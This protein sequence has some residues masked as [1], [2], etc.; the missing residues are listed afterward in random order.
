MVAAAQNTNNMTIRS[1]L[2]AEKLTGSKFTNWYS[3]YHETV[4]IGRVRSRRTKKAREAK[5]KDNGKNKLAYD[6]KPKIPPP[7]KR[8]NPGKDF[9]CH[10]CK[11]GLRERKKLKHGALSLY[12]GNGMLA[13]VETIGSFD[14]ILP[15]GILI[16][17]ENYHFAPFVTRGVVL[18]SRLVNNGYIHTFTNYGISVSKDNVFYFNAIPRNGI[19]EIDTHNLYPNVSSMFNVNNKR[20]KH[21]LDSSYL[22]YCRLGH[23]NKK[24][25]DKLQRDGILQPTH[26]ESLEKCKSCI[27]EKMARKSF[28]HQVERAKDL[29]GLIHT[30]GCEALVKRDAPDKLDPRSI[31][32]IFIG[33][34]KETISYYFYYPFENKIFVAQNAEF[35]ENRLMS[36][37]LSKDNPKEILDGKLQ[38]GDTPMIEKHDYRK[39]QGAKTPSEVQY[40]KSAKKSTNAMSSTEAEYIAAAEASMES[41]WM[42]KFIVGLGDDNVVDPFTKPM[43][44]D[45]HYE[46]A[47]A[48]G[49]VPA[50]SRIEVDLSKDMSGLESPPRTLKKLLGDEGLSS[51]GTQ[52]N[53]IFITADV[54]LTKPNDKGRMNENPDGTHQTSLTNVKT[55]FPSLAFIKENIDVLRTMINE[56]DQQAKMKA[57]P[58]KLAYANSDKEAPA[59]KVKKVGRLEH[60]Q[61][62][63]KKGK[64]QT[65]REK[66]KRYAKDPTEIHDIK[67]RQNEGLQ[68][69][70]DR[71]KSQ[72][73]HIKGVPSVLRISAFMHGHGH[74]ELTKKL[75]DKIPKTVD[76]MFERVRA[77]I[78]EEVA[79]GSVE[80]VCPSPGDKG[81]I[82]P[83]WTGGPEKARNRGDPREVRRNMGVYTPYHRKDTFTPL[84]KTPKKI[85]AMESNNQRSRNQGRNDVKVINL[86]REGV[87]R[88]RPFEKGRSDIVRKTWDKEDTKEV[89]TISHERPDQYITIRTTLTTDCKQLLIKV[90]RENIE[91]WMTRK[92]RHPMWVANT[93][94]V[95]LAN[96][97]WKVQVDYSSLNKV[98]AKDMYPF[99]EEG[100]GLASII[101]YPYKCFLRLLKE[102]NQIRMTEDDEEKTG[103]HTEE[104]VYCFIHMLKELK[105]SAATLQ[106][107][108]EK[109]LAYKKG[110]NVK[111][112]LEE[113]VIK[114][115]SE[116]DPIQDVEVTLRKLKRVN[117]KIDPVTS[118]FR[119]KEGRKEAEGS[120]VKKFFGQ[121]EQVEETPD[122][123]KW[124]TLNLSKKLQAKSTLTPR[125]WRLYIGRETIEEGSGVGIILV[126]PEEKMY[127]YAIRLKFNASNHAMDC[128]ALLVGL[129]A[130]TNQGTK[131]LHYFIDSLTLV[132]QVERNHA[133]ATEQ[134]RKYKE[135]I[136]DV[137]ALLYRFG[138]THLPKIL[139]LKVELLTWLATIKLDFL[140]QEVL[141][142]IKTRPSVEETSSTKK[143]KET[144]NMP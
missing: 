27:S 64:V 25:I 126:S 26:D 70:M 60:N 43:P 128:E 133:L 31:K 49:I 89:F 7:P 80:M 106:K 19:Y 38:E 78:R 67:R 29:L 72:S 50:S 37:C 35:F 88:K 56:H 117:I 123:N 12:M 120:A 33:Y 125:A 48:I 138:I 131:D 142:G 42:R 124:G 24:R 114:S 13:T 23:I 68:A 10:H 9:V 73:S 141:V 102:Y 87:N 140:N 92:V 79:A 112:Y 69:F 36:I 129:A 55:P 74:P 95:K 111:I 103:F 30:D 104:G 63:I 34:S 16:V 101:G 28:P 45:K 96:E 113:I 105:N 143:G 61:G 90:M 100:E 144:S 66:H 118:L 15:S 71:F 11:E 127:S 132:S 54:T 134:E 110:Q 84:I 77:F 76:E 97:T 47:M 8:D 6:P 81:Y 21:A 57:T 130:S 107:M 39:S 116:P 136:L 53:S 119:I 17:L 85:L 4:N 18:V 52:L 98:C 137:T 99:S 75:N 65:Q 139:N 3:K 94:P 5:G 86:I 108:M 14:L 58:R 83:A 20:A 32:C 22:W 40:R 41:I 82:H 44:L 1:I 93:I 51:G 62:E 121:G 59:R 109:V 115:K 91:E 122:A 135:E 2:L 46:Y